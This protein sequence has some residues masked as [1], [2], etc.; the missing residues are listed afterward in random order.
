MSLTWSLCLKVLICKL[1]MKRIYWI[2]IEHLERK[3]INSPAFLFQHQEASSQKPCERIQHFWNIKCDF[4]A[5]H[6]RTYTGTRTQS[7][8]SPGEN[9]QFR[10]LRCFFL[11]TKGDLKCSEVTYILLYDMRDREIKFTE[12][13]D[14]EHWDKLGR[15]EGIPRGKQTLQYYWFGSFFFFFKYMVACWWPAGTYSYVNMLMFSDYMS[16]V[17]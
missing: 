2:W 14:A 9:F 16:K 13:K 6:T 3:Q 7:L 10:S 4:P 15:T 5:V 17:C 11:L 12:K 1:K 8:I